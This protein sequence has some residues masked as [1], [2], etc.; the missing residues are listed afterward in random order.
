MRSDEKFWSDIIYKVC[1][2]DAANMREL[3]RL[4]VFEFFNYLENWQ[5]DGK[6]SRT[7]NKSGHKPIR[8][9]D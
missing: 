2:G 3:R 6:R 9:G 7:R 4:D 1:K 8:Q 5:E